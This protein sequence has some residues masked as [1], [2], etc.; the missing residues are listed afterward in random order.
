MF[1]AAGAC[2]ESPFIV[3][4]SV[5]WSSTGFLLFPFHVMRYFP[6]PIHV[7]FLSLSWHHSEQKKRRTRTGDFLFFFFK[8][9]RVAD[10]TSL[11]CLALLCLSAQRK[12]VYHWALPLAMIQY[13]MWIQCRWVMLGHHIKCSG[14]S[15]VLPQTHRFV[16]IWI[17]RKNGLRSIRIW[18]L[19]EPYPP[20][21]KTDSLC[22]FICSL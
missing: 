20:V 11:A 6:L 13:T 16:H 12:E 3:W 19:F 5:P 18:M 15:L 10:R 17:K 8:A 14:S 2:R 21:E 22:G 7:G 4:T 9:T 1:W